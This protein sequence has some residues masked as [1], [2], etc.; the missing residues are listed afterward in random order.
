MER[1]QATC[2][3]CPLALYSAPS[4]GIQWGSSEEHTPSFF[5]LVKEKG[6]P[7]PRPLHLS[8]PPLCCALALPMG[9]ELAGSSFLARVAAQGKEDRNRHGPSLGR[10]LSPR[11]E[12]G[13]QCPGDR[14]RRLGRGLGRA[15]AIF[16]LPHGAAERMR[17]EGAVFQS[18]CWYGT[19]GPPG[20]PSLGLLGLSL[21]LFLTETQGR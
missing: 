15:A 5:P 13:G 3:P 10:T 6:P 18:P 7:R 19:V 11:D 21:M 20:L 12:E 16:L 4:V 1:R 14:E 9:G 17:R 2:L 8:L